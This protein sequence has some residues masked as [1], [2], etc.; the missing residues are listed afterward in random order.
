MCQ[1][2]HPF[3]P[4]ELISFIKNECLQRKKDEVRRIFVQEFQKAPDEIFAEFD[5][6]PIA[7]ASLAQVFRAK[8]KD[9]ED[10]AVKV[11]YIDLAKRFSGDFATILFLQDI[12]KLIHANFNFGW[13]LRDLRSNLEQELDFIHEG[14]N[15]ERCAKELKKFNFIRV[16]KVD[17]DLTTKVC[18]Y[19]IYISSGNTRFLLNKLPLFTLQ[20]ILTTEWIDGYKI[21]DMDNIRKDK[22]DLADIDRKLFQIF[23]EQIFNTGFVHADPHPGNGTSIIFIYS[24]L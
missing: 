7:A 14:H 6:E 8:T 22:F 18:S 9:G 5:Y 12:I 13:I 21:S 23:S 10:V 1:P 11:Q 20:R 16:P 24:F 3:C 2:I 15:A 17:W 19:F 4:I